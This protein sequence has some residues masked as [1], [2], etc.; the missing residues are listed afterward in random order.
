[1][2]RNQPRNDLTLLLVVMILACSSQVIA[3][4]SQFDG[5]WAYE[6]T[7]GSQHVASVQL[8]QKG[9][10]VS[11]KWSDGSTR[12][13]GTSGQLKGRG[14]NNKLFVRYCGDDE[15]TSSNVCPSYDAEVSDY[16]MRQGN[17]LIWYKT[18]D[19]G[20]NGALDKYL[21]LHP[22][23]NGKPTVKDTHCDNN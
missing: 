18:F 22:T 12:G 15:N 5:N 9:D 21:V 20:K 7:C 1:M 2:Y 19:S 14:K 6:Q 23:I 16:F 11:G 13:S 17:D 3:A 4:D 8:S 10:Q